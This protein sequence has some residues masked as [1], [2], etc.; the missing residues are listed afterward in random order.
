MKNANVTNKRNIYKAM[1]YT[2]KVIYEYINQRRPKTETCG[3]LAAISE[4]MEKMPKIRTTSTITGS[5]IV[6]L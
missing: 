6:I 5:T 3:I 2:A 1:K 4:A